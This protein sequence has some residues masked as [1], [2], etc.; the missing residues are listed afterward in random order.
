MLMTPSVV[1]Q[2]T[3]N[4]S[5]ATSGNNTCGSPILLNLKRNMFADDTKAL[6]ADEPVN[7]PR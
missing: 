1:H 3:V 2:T 6:A 5:A 4:R 7:A